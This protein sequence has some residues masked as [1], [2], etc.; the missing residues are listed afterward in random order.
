MHCVGE[1]TQKYP[2]PCL[3]FNEIVMEIFH[4][5]GSENDNQTRNISSG[6]FSLNFCHIAIC[7]VGE[8]LMF[9]LSMLILLVL[10]VMIY[11]NRL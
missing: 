10:M 4:I 11:I 5:A 2:L 1:A 6:K 7:T 3:H 8:K 9:L